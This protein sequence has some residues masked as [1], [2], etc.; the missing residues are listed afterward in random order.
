MTFASFFTVEIENL[1]YS[2]FRSI[3]PNDLEHG[4][5]RSTA[6]ERR[7]LPA[8]FPCPALDLRLTGNHLCG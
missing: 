4:W 6:V 7:S 8:N 1:P 3:W 5:L 2:Y